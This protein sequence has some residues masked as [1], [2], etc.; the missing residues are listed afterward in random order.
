MAL[1]ADGSAAL[2]AWLA[3]IGASAVLIRPDRYIHGVAHDDASLQALL[4][5][6]F[7]ALPTE[8]A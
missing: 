2:G 8:H 4:S 5:H 1:V 7:A 6:A 3:E